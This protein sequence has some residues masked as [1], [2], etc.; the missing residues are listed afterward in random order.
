MS[1]SHGDRE[2]MRVLIACKR[3]NIAGRDRS[4][5]CLC[6]DCKYAK[7]EYRKRT[8]ARKRQYCKQWVAKNPD[9][10]K[11]YS[12]KWIKNHRE[13][14]RAIERS[15]REKNADKVRAMSAS[16]GAKWSAGKGRAK[17]N[18]LTR[19]RVAAKLRRTPFWSDLS[20]M[21]G[22][23]EEALRITR[24]TGVPHEVDHVIP[25][26]GKTVSGLHVAGN[27]QVIPRSMNRAKGNLFG[28]ALSAS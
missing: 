3:G 25:L 8:A 23:Y 21:E 27:L 18:L 2:V 10:A 28:G 13:Q 26:Q 24:E 4:G 15:W 11:S 12:R 22:F 17:R 19:S 20:A 5:H 6:V 9:R 7:A 16:G 14:R 1:G